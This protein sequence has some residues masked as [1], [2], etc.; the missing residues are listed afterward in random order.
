MITLTK[1]LSFVV[2]FPALINAA[3]YHSGTPLQSDDQVTWVEKQLSTVP[4]HQL[5]LTTS[6]VVPTYFHIITDGN[7]GELHDMQI[8]TQLRVFNERYASYGISFKLKGTTK[9]DNKFWYYNCGLDD[10]GDNLPA[11]VEMKTALRKGGR[12]T[13]NVYFADLTNYEGRTG[14]SSFPFDIYKKDDISLDG[15]VMNNKAIPGGSREHKNL[16]IQLVH[17]SGHWLGLFHVFQGKSCSSL[18]DGVD[19]TPAEATEGDDSCPIGRDTCPDLPGLDV[20]SSQHSS[21]CITLFN[22]QSH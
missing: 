21:F 1:L 7:I 22:V 15:I 18:G 17:E 4:K 6:I 8:Q 10:N 19:D 16:G 9:T 11:A 12:K 2:A 14:Y 3:E 5:K 13:L 20:S